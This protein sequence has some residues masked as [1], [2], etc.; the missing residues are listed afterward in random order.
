VGH[1]GRRIR[2]VERSV[3][4]L[5]GHGNKNGVLESGKP[6]S[7][8]RHRSIGKRFSGEI[9]GISPYIHPE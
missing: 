4:F 1:A 2:G 8:P 6:R 7:S 9:T 3:L 5:R